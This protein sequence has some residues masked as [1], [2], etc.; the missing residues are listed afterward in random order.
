MERSAKVREYLGHEL[1]IVGPAD[2]VAAV[3]RRLEDEHVGSALV[4]EEGALVGIITER[5][6]VRAVADGVDPEKALASD[7][8]SRMLT[9]IATDETMAEAARLMTSQRIR[10]LPVVDRDQLVGVLSIRDIVQWSVRE[11]PHDEGR[12][13]SQLVDLV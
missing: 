7:Y 9:T 3:C 1:V 13:L 11:P 2:P 10:H 8:M 6:V 4:V 5:D 12:H